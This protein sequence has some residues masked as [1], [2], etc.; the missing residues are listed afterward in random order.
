[1][2]GSIVVVVLLMGTLVPL[3]NRWRKQK[4]LEQTSAENLSF[5]KASSDP[6]TGAKPV[7]PR[8]AA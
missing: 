6:G 7:G 2:L 5:T 3:F 8:K 4:L 1:M